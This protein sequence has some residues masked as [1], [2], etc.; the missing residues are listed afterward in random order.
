M[1]G[2]KVVIPG[3]LCSSKSSMLLMMHTGNCENCKVRAPERILKQH[4]ISSVA[5]YAIDFLYK[6]KYN[7]LLIVSKP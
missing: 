5:G 4:V 1:S 6:M 2:I 7:V 3:L